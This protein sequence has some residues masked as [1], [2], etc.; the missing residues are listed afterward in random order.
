[1]NSSQMVVQMACFDSI[2]SRFGFKMEKAAYG[3]NCDSQDDCKKH[4][5]SKR[6]VT[7]TTLPTPLPSPV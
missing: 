2:D 1:M 5:P 6:I 4:R 7:D 3:K